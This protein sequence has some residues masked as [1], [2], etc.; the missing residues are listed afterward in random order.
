MVSSRFSV[1]R[2]LRP[3]VLA[4]L[5][6]VALCVAAGCS[7]NAKTKPDASILDAGSDSRVADAWRAPDLG[8]IGDDFAIVVAPETTLCAVFGTR[9][10]SP[11][12]VREE[13][14]Q[15]AR[16]LLRAGVIRLP[17]TGETVNADLVERL[18]HGP[19]ATVL[20]PREG[21]AFAR[22]LNGT[23][24][25]GTYQYAFSQS[26]SAG[27][28]T[29]SLAWTLSF[30]VTGGKAQQP[31]VTMDPAYT[32]KISSLFNFQGGLDGLKRR[33]LSCHPPTGAAQ[34]IEI[35]GATA[36]DAET[37]TFV[38]KIRPGLAPIMPVQ[39]ASAS[40]S[41]GNETRA[42]TDYFSMVYDAGWHNFEQK[43]MV[44]FDRPVGTTH[45][46]LVE[47]NGDQGADSIVFLD[48]Q[49]QP[50]TPS[51]LSR[52]EVTGRPY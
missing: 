45:G 30:A 25:D 51:A 29:Y 16:I 50:G 32:W 46:F 1:F 41:R 13:W 34:R 35:S 5:C 37:F 14:D 12:P 48:A 47:E 17:R 4:R 44:V 9:D 22:T 33:F 6:V 20:T 3:A 24:D 7:D 31:V 11:G 38:G 23:P 10:N 15:Q 28:H 36:G 18:E 26:F 19:E 49:L 8:D 2:V 43:I 42:M 40:F 21:G 52:Y 27:T 39:V